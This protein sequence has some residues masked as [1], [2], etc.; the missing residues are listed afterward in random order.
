MRTDLLLHFL[1][2][3]FIATCVNMIVI[4]FGNP[5]S[6]WIGT[7]VAFGAGLLKELY[8]KFVKHS[9]FDAKDFVLTCI[10]GSTALWVDFIKM[11]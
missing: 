6:I 2:G 9:I 3:F 10:G 11:I 7:L 4:H 8:D 1:A 5:A